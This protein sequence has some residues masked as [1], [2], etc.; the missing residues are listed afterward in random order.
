M[1][2]EKANILPH[3]RSFAN[4]RFGKTRSSPS[5]RDTTVP[6]SSMPPESCRRGSGS[7][8]Q[9]LVSEC[10]RPLGDARASRL[11]SL[12]HYLARALCSRTGCQQPLFF[13]NGSLVGSPHALQVRRGNGRVIFQC[14]RISHKN[15]SPHCG[16]EK[17]S[18]QNINTTDETIALPIA[19]PTGKCTATTTD[20]IKRTKTNKRRYAIAHL[21]L[22]VIFHFLQ[23]AP[24][25][26]IRLAFVPN[27]LSPRG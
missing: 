25:A 15:G 11:R 4:G 16:H 14:P 23:T 7:R 24:E 17:V 22:D 26:I 12:E 27:H 18:P 3:R 1:R 20:G 21:P 5:G 10:W 9:P 8:K 13:T 2:A 6:A 19:S